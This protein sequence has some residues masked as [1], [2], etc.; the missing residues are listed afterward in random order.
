MGWGQALGVLGRWTVSGWG[1]VGGWARWC[2]LGA[3]GCGRWQEGPPQ[4][5]CV[6]G[7]PAAPGAAS[8][9]PPGYGPRPCLSSAGSDFSPS[10]RTP[11]GGERHI[12]VGVPRCP[13]YLPPRVPSPSPSPYATGQCVNAGGSGLGAGAQG[14]RSE[15]Q[16]VCGSGREPG[17]GCWLSEG[18]QGAGTPW[19]VTR[20]APLSMRF[21]RQEHWSGL[22]RP[23]PGDLPEPGIKPG[24]LTSPAVAGGL[25]TTNSPGKPLCRCISTS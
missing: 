13:R 3:W 7:G 25:L 12:R 5:V 11:E 19:N 10:A 16:N 15:L 20:Q 17:R 14:L 24:S 2:S 1:G 21:S 4:R 6:A 9:A 22:P 18:Q 8:L 23:P